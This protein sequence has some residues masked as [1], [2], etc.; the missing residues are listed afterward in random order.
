MEAQQQ[1]HLAAMD[2]N[3]ELTTKVSGKKNGLIDK[4]QSALWESNGSF[5]E[6]DAKLQE[7]TEKLKRFEVDL[8]NSQEELSQKLEIIDD[9]NA[10][11]ASRVSERNEFCKEIETMRDV[12]R[13]LRSDTAD[14]ET[15]LR[16]AHDKIKNLEEDLCKHLTTIDYLN[17]ELTSRISERNGL[18]A[19][20]IED[21]K[22][23][24]EAF[25][26]PSEPQEVR[27]EMKSAGSESLNPTSFVH[28]FD[29]DE[30]SDTEDL[31]RKVVMES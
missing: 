6:K 9:L 27:K 7:V 14:K 17:T 19:E 10:E 15:N 13:E 8:Q 31:V 24:G 4:L 18:L 22:F 30:L 21:Q 26:N 3:T 28:G 1:K 5:A 11:L 20:T 29:Q 16:E 23:D 2:F 12:L 25:D